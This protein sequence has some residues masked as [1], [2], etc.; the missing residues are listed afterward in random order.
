MPELRTADIEVTLAAVEA[1]ERELRAMLNRA[2]PGAQEQEVDPL[3]PTPFRPATDALDN[4]IE[5]LQS[6]PFTAAEADEVIQ[7]VAEAAETKNRVAQGV[8]FG[9]VA[10]EHLKGVLPLLLGMPIP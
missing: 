7:R 1:L 9:V 2:N 5:N 6:L 3:M 4:A 8:K 10:V